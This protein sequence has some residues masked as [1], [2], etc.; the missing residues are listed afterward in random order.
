MTYPGL[1]A[2]ALLLTA[3]TPLLRPPAEASAFQ[4]PASEEPS[5]ATV[6]AASVLAKMRQAY[7]GLEA[8]H[9]EGSLLITYVDKKADST[10]TQESTFETDYR[11]PDAFLYTMYEPFP[12]LPRKSGEG[13]QRVVLR[14]DG[15]R[16]VLLQSWAPPEQDIPRLPSLLVRAG[17][18]THLGSTLVPGLI[19][20]NQIGGAGGLQ[21]RECRL[22][23][24]TELRGV[25]CWKLT[26]ADPVGNPQSVWIGKSDHLIRRID[27]AFDAPTQA[28]TRR[29]DYFP[30][31]SGDFPEGTFEPGRD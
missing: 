6:D 23:G 13:R 22:A 7:L 19:F 31:L 5:E 25:P 27:I 26:G 9:D 29:F 24:T 20:R 12:G 30:D 3:A 17:A 10:R 2:V 15:S 11:G 14:S 21:F 28:S 4:Q 18:I 1:Q 8:Y 16:H